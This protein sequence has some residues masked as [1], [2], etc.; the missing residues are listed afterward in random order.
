MG[1]RLWLLLLLPKCSRAEP[2]DVKECSG[3]PA[4]GKGPWGAG[5]CAGV[6]GSIMEGSG[7]SVMAGSWTGFMGGSRAIGYV[8]VGV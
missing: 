6:P 4:A 2:G 3:V 7:G 8:V 5:I 1:G